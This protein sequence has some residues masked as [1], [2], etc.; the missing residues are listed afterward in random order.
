MFG[1]WRWHRENGCRDDPF[2]QVIDALEAA[3]RP[4]RE[5]PG[6]EQPFQRTLAITPVPPS[7]AA[8]PVG[9][10][11]TGH[12]TARAHLCQDPVDVIALFAGEAAPVTATRGA[13]LCH[14]PPQQW[15][16]REGHQGGHVTPVL[17]ERGLFATRL[18]FEQLHVI[19]AEA[20]EGRQIVGAG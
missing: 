16:Q 6:S 10:I 17:E 15:L 4:D 9:E 8:G 7:G 20:R 5:E 13:G 2:S 11:A 1:R 3:P 18:L 14:S 12:W 19:R